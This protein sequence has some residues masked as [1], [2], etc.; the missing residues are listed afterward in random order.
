MMMDSDPGKHHVGFDDDCGFHKFSI[1][2]DPSYS[3]DSQPKWFD[4]QDRRLG[5][6]RT[7]DSNRGHE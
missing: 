3:L 6:F 7:S 2:P 5:D 4:Y 1:D